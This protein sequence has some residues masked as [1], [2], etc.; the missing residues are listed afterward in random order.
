MLADWSTRNDG[1]CWLTGQHVMTIKMLADWSTR[2]DGGD[3]G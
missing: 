3:V 1:R 2:N